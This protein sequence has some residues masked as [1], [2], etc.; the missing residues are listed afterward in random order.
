M[1]GL[2]IGDIRASL[3]DQLRANLDRQT[4]VYAY[5]E[6][7]AIPAVAFTLDDT[8]T[9]WVSFGETGL[10]SVTFL[11]RVIPGVANR[12]TEIRL[13][14]YFSAGTGNGSSVVDALLAGGTLETAGYSL[15]FEPRGVARE[16]RLSVD[17]EPYEVL[18]GSMA[19]TVTVQKF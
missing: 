5:N 10:S 16:T 18:V 13:E 17:G 12:D 6:G 2:S 14:Q 7:L 11:V 3:A 4:N 9:Y 15:D 8:P 1:A 19:V